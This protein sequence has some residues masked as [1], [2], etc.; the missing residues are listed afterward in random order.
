MSLPPAVSACVSR[1][2]ALFACTALLAGCTTSPTSGRAQFNILPG[3]LETTVPD[4]RFDVK[5]LLAAGRE[6]CKEEESPCPAQEA[7]GKLA[8]R[9]APIAERLGTLT[10]E[11]SPELVTRV[12]HVEVFVV[13]NDSPSV[14]S[15]A[16]GKIAVSSGLARLDLTDTE[17]ALALAREFGRLAAAHHRESTSAGLA[18]SLVAGSPLTSAYLATSILADIIFPMGALAKVGISLLASMGTEQ[19]VEV[20]QQDEADE[21]AGKLLLEAG[22]D[23]RELTEARPDAPEGTVKI[24]WL[25]NYFA[26]RAK[27]AAM[28]PPPETT[29]EMARDQ[30]LPPEAKAEVAAPPKEMAGNAVAAPESPTEAM[31]VAAATP[32]DMTAATGNEQKPATEAKDE[33]I[34]PPVEM[35]A[36]AAA[37]PGPPPAERIEVPTPAA[38]MTSPAPASPQPVATARAEAAELPRQSA[39]TPEVQENPPAAKPAAKNAKQG[40]AKPLLK[41]RKKIRKPSKKPVR[42]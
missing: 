22:Y 4:L 37:N 21:F 8:Q 35:T 40:A 38:E 26:S 1:A 3:T 16:G 23:L 17:L 10:A 15:S 13:P 32:P 24:G 28:A 18:V 36:K 42:R 34:A 20:S 7:A 29:A 2:V 41:K 19:L 9:I 12:P 30:E 6:F 27:V 25:P 14:S 33:P 5:T 39:E 11:M 31:P